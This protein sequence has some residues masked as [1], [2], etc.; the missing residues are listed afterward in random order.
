M[1]RPLHP[2]TGCRSGMTLIELLL[3]ITIFVLVVGTI[4]VSLKAATTALA[5][6]KESMEMYQTTRAGL[7]RM[8]LDLRR[9]LGPASFPFNEREEEDPLAEGDYYLDEEGP[10]MQVTF[11]GDSSSVQFVVRQ[12]M[13]TEN[14]PKMDIREVRYKVSEKGKLVKEIYRSLLE[15]RLAEIQARRMEQRNPMGGDTLGRTR[16]RFEP[17]PN[18]GFFEK[19]IVQTLCDKVEEVKFAYYDGKDWRDNWDSEEVVINEFCRDLPEDELTEED[20]ERIGL[21]RLVRVD[22]RVTEDVRLSTSTAIPAA[23]LNIVSARANE[24]DFGTAYRASIDRLERLK[25]GDRSLVTSRKI[26]D[27]GR[28]DRRRR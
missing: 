9:A 8:V 5:V 18:A 25:N 17:P 22:V 6:G 14:G 7:N 26:G 2:S 19:P 21:P 10:Q 23:D 3:A 1:T 20:E 15:A 4:F 12:E 28:R 11:K 16:P 13:E 24:S 27:R